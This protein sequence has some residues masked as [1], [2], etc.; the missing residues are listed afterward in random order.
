MVSRVYGKS[1]PDPQLLPDS[2]TGCLYSTPLSVNPSVEALF[3]ATSSS[4]PFLLSSPSF[5]CLSV[6]FP[7]WSLEEAGLSARQLSLIRAVAVHRTFYCQQILSLLELMPTVSDR[8]AVLEIMCLRIADVSKK[9]GLRDAFPDEMRTVVNG[10]LRNAVADAQDHMRMQPMLVKHQSVQT[11]S[12]IR[13]LKDAVDNAVYSTNRF[14]VLKAT[15][16]R[17]VCGFSYDQAFELLL[18]FE[19]HISNTVECLKIIEPYL[20]GFTSREVGRWIMD[21]PDFSSKMRMLAV[22]INSV[23]DIE[24]K[25]EILDI[26]FPADGKESRAKVKQKL[27]AA[28][29][30]PRSFLFGDIGKAS[31]EDKSFIVFLLD[32]SRPMECIYTTNQGEHIS[33]W[34]VVIRELFRCLKTQCN[35]SVQVCISLLWAVL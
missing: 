30:Y 24:N 8:L 34:H 4:N 5:L 14:D 28:P 6:H 1:V 27:H 9:L 22:L 26:G 31:P 18:K 2:P 13:Q 7:R 17:S 21:M 15:I 16:G 35:P 10:L 11:L 25:W 19:G 32:C 29:L 20:L 12:E 23:L 3:K 33:R